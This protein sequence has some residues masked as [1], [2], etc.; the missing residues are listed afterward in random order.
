MDIGPV[1]RQLDARVVVHGEVAERVCAG[2]AW[3]RQ[4][5]RR[6]N[7]NGGDRE[8]A[9]HDTAF[10]ATGAHR[11]EKAGLCA[12]ASRYQRSISLRSPAQPAA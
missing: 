7:E 2:T 4:S 1:P 12:S 9:P 3:Q 11:T 8:P 10:R 5:R 6:E